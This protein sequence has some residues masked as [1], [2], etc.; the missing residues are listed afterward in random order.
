MN[1]E[2]NLYKRTEIESIINQQEFGMKSELATA[3]DEKT[4]LRFIADRLIDIT[5]ELRL[6]SHTKL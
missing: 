5:M 6:I 2:E 4:L 3:K 1:K